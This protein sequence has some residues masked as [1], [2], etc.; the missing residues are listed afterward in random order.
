MFNKTLE[1]RL[2][3]RQCRVLLRALSAPTRTPA[4]LAKPN[5]ITPHTKFG[6]QR[7][8]LEQG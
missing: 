6:G 1:I 7:L 8:Y 5:S 4:R 2:A 3:G